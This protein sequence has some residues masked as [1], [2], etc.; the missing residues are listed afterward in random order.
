MNDVTAPP[1]NALPAAPWA[2][3]PVLTALA[4]V[5]LVNMTAQFAST[6]LADIQGGLGASSDEVSWAS[7][8]YVAGNFAGIIVSGALAT[9]FGLRR[10]FVGSTFV[11]AGC[12]LG[13]ALAPSLLSFISMRAIQGVAA[14]GFGPVAFIAI[15]T[16][17]KGPR[18]PF[19]LAML[20]FALLLSVGSGPVVAG[21]VEAAL[22]WRSLFLIQF[23]VSAPLALAGILWMP[24]AA[25]NWKGLQIDWSAIGLLVVATASLMIVLS[26][27]TR[28]FWL[29]D[30]LIAW[31][32]IACI[33]AGA[34]FLFHCR[35]SP[36]AV[37]RLE[38]FADR[39]FGITILL[40]LLFRSSLA[41]TFYLIPLQ[42]ALTH[43]YRP[44]Q[45]AS[46]LLWCL[47]PQ[48]L[49]FPLVWRA[50]H[51]VDGRLLIAS[52]LLLCAIGS[53]MAAFTTHD[54]AG[55]QLRLSLIVIGAGQML[56][57]VPNL[58]IGAGS[59][60]PQDLPTASL[61]FNMTTVGGATLGIGLLSNYIT[62]RQ[63]F[64]SS[65]LAEQPSLLQHESA[66]RLAVLTNV[67]SGRVVDESA[68]LA[69]AATMLAEGVRREA[70]VLAIGDGFA[71]AS[72]LLVLAAFLALG[73]DHCPPLRALGVNP[74]EGK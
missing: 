70:W 36:V 67:I 22:G 63:K 65:V 42:L 11:F 38:K 35:Y 43:S 58:L 27:G 53:A 64:H 24:P 4:G 19:A 16:R 18:L 39:R 32:T 15:F 1:V 55:E 61:A 50:L 17:C 72:V 74:D 9:T 12:A 21:A 20:A 28:R 57:M 66:E 37:L 31:A 29:E 56:F 10:Y 68:A 73:I 23:W 34:G 54:V 8:A 40:N 44:E 51:W 41:L 47:V 14:G 7:T 48:A 33:G 30:P 62:E 45:V 6:S 60:K 52:G 2:E 3:P 49:V 59:L 26:Q 46:L 71:A 25:P 5:L 13:C 69:S